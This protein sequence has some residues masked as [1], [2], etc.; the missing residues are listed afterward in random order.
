MKFWSIGL[1]WWI[2]YGFLF[3]FVLLVFDLERTLYQI[4]VTLKKLQSDVE[5]GFKDELEELQNIDTNIRI[6]PID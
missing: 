5:F 1:E 3:I 6:S 2:L 4:Q